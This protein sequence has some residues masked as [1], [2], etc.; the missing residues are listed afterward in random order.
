VPSRAHQLLLAFVGVGVKNFYEVLTALLIAVLWRATDRGLVQLRWALGS[1]LFGELMCEANVLFSSGASDSLETL[2]GLGMVGMGV[3]LPM[4]IANLLDERV[5]RYHD[6]AATCAF[7]RFCGHCWKREKVSCGLQRL[8]LFAALVL[9]GVALMPFASPIAPGRQVVEIF[10]TRV[11]YAMSADLQLIEY[12]VYPAIACLAALVSFAL[13]WG[14]RATF[15]WA[16]RFFF[17]SVGFLT[18]ALFRWVIFK[19][20]WPTAVWLDFW[21]E[22]TELAAIVGVGVGLWVF[23]RQLG[24]FGFLDRFRRQTGTAAPG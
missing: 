23:R 5:I 9:A 20:Y 24:L 22:M 11:I 13:L 19:A 1:F 7:Q 12:R 17:V 8:F 15:E 10:G 16:K 4:G 21:E 6:P 18:F 14:G 2:H 3:L